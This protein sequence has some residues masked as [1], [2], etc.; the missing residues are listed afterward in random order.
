MWSR[1][2]AHR[3]ISLKSITKFHLDRYAS[4]F[5]GSGSRLELF[6]AA[7]SSTSEMWSKFKSAAHREIVTKKIAHNGVDLYGA[8]FAAVTQIRNFC[9]LKI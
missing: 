3:E 8:H 2:L 1:F 5:G 6:F 7:L 9:V 4:L